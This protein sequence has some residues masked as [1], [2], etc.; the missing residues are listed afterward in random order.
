MGKLVKSQQSKK[1]TR[2]EEQAI[3]SYLASAHPDSKPVSRYAVQ[4][5]FKR[6]GKRLTA[7]YKVGTF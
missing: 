5:E 7:G 6:Y 1:Y 3:D 4:W 2:E